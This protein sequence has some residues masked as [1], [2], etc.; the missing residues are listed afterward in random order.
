MSPKPRVYVIILNWNNYKDT[1]NCLQSLQATS[2][3]DLKIIVLDNGSTDNSGLLLREEFPD[4][5]FIRNEENLGFARGCNV[6]IRAALEDPL[7]AYVLLLN[8]DAELTG[9]GLIEAIE[10]AER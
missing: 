5:I 2:Y 9:E 3:P 7:G 6:G 1:K 4:V 10:A 8:N